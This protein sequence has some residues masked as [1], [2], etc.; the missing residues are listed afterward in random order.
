[1]STNI[2]VVMVNLP[3][4]K[5]YSYEELPDGI[6]TLFLPMKVRIGMNQG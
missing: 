3:N 6:K 4:R 1:M 5:L 2:P